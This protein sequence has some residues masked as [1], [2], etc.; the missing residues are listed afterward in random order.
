M[1]KRMACCYYPTTVVLIDDDRRFLRSTAFKVR[2]HWNFSIMLTGQIPLPSAAC[3]CRKNAPL[4][5][6]ASMLIYD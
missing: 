6:K 5:S 3:S 2:R 4:T 1:D